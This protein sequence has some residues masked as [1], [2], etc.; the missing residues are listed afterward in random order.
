MSISL[1]KIEK[2]KNKRYGLYIEDDTFL[3]DI[4]EDTLVHFALSKGQVYAQSK[5]DEIRRHD[6]YISCLHQAF[7]YLERRPH[8]KKELYRKL[9][10]KSFPERS[11]DQ[12][13]DYLE[14]KQYLDDLD[15]IRRFINDQV[16][17][18]KNGFLLI[19]KKLI[20]KG[21]KQED[22]ERL[23]LLYYN[24][25]LQVANAKALLEKKKSKLIETDSNKAK[26]KLVRHL[27]QK[28][29]PW[30][31]IETALE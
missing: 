19:K 4:D 7:R 10:Q 15:F 8:L 25:N 26:Q 24:E 2:L 23:L 13:M 16:R 27:Q 3:F 6:E 21:A 11:I 1:T 18:K 28:G 12:T 22:A 17:L 5:I 14:E 20:E 29:F 30:R 31:I 9:K